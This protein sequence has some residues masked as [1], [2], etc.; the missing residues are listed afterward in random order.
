MAKKDINVGIWGPNKQGHTYQPA[1]YHGFKAKPRSGKSRWVKDANFE[2]QLFNLADEHSGE[3][4]PNAPDV[5][6]LRWMN[7]DNSGLFSI[8]DQGLTVLG[9]AG[10]R[11]AFFPQPRNEEDS[12]HGYPTNST[13]IGDELVDYWLSANVISRNVYRKL[14]KH[15]I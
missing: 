4:L 13:N 6:D 2:F 1:Y 7:D 15:V 5:E 3:K 9:Q 10:E 8:K 12:W 11:L 14:I